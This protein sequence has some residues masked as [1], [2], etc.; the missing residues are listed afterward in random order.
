MAAVAAV[1]LVRALT[2]LELP[3][4]G[5]ELPELPQLA[6]MGDGGGTLV[7]ELSAAASGAD[8]AYNGS[9]PGPVVRLR[10]GDRVRL[11]FRNLT[12]ADSSLHLHGLP[13]TAEVDRP[14]VHVAPGGSDTREFVLPPGSAGTY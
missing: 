7:G 8:L 13:L 5:P 10:E 9:T 14:L 4:D 3:T 6:L 11:G 1:P 12:D 2:D